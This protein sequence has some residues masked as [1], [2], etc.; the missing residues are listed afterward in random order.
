MKDIRA[1]LIDWK[2]IY[3]RMIPG[4]I[5]LIDLYYILLRTS[6]GPNLQLTAVLIYE[7]SKVIFC[8]IFILIGYIVGYVSMIAYYFSFGKYFSRLCPDIR[9]VLEDPTIDSAILTYLK[10]HFTEKY[11]L[12]RHLLQ[13]YCKTVLL[14]QNP[15]AYS[16]L[17]HLEGGRS[18]RQG[19]S[20]GFLFTSIVLFL[21][22]WYILAIFCLLGFPVFLIDFWLATRN[23][24]L[25]T[26]I[27]YYQANIRTSPDLADTK[28][29]L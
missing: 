9:N 28:T 18:I 16:H 24:D 8:S 25:E 4:M 26:I 20:L 13:K 21:Y 3:G 27:L 12:D 6:I 10:N 5:I 14:H 17:E 23:R 2:D 7:S 1:I 15:H 29:E 22:G 11:L 19:L